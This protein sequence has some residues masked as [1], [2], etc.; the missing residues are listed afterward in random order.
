[1]ELEMAL[2]AMM[3]AAIW[4]ISRAM[5]SFP[6]WNRLFSMPLGRPTPMIR[7]IIFR[8]KVIRFLFVRNTG[9]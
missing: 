4:E 2:A 1:M 8:S 7:R 5:S 9:I 6:T 3:L